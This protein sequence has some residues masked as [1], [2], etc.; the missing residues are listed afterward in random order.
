MLCNGVRKAWVTIS[1]RCS[2]RAP[3]GTDFAEGLDLAGDVLC[4][5]TKKCVSVGASLSPLYSR[6][7]E[8]EAQRGE[9]TG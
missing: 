4:A 8:T 7:G 9:G 1:P 5:A 3:R 2:G 6:K